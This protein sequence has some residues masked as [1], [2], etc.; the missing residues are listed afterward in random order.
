MKT[1]STIALVILTFAQA[2]PADLS[3]EQRAEQQ[4]LLAWA[5]TLRY[6]ARTEQA[7]AVCEMILAADPGC[8]EARLEHAV[9]EL[10][11][12]RLPEALADFSD[13]L[14]R[15]RQNPMALV[16]R[17]H[18]HYAQQDF[19]H[20]DRNARK[21]LAACNEAISVDRAN[22]QTWYVR[23]LAKM[24]LK[25]DSA[26]QDF[27]MALS[28]DPAHMDAHTER[29]QIYR[30]RG[31]TQDA[32]DQLTRAVEVRPDYAVG[33]LARARVHYEAGDPAASVA[34][35]DRALQ[36]NPQCARAWHNRGLVNI[37]L[38][39]YPEAIGDLTEAIAAEPDYASAHVYRGEAH[40]E[41][42]DLEAARADWEA[43]IS[44]DPDGWAGRTAQDM[45]R[46]AQ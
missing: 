38:E 1:A 45:L 33:Y 41:A 27:V 16:G 37:D 11:Q 9:L 14:K 10:S 31:R 17:G 13:V 28:L 2:A 19:E 7:L 34:D 44:L 21:A 20:A 15:D 18:V 6:Q 40:A 46:A 29:A 36:I 24:L 26:L 25:D 32:L 8:V 5:T 4:E 30:A 3:A 12:S 43:A 42:G 35:C 39:N 23:G 22:A